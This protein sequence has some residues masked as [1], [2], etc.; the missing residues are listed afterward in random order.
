LDAGA[1]YSTYL[2]NT[3]SSNQVINVNTTGTYEVTVTDNNGCKGSGNVKISTTL[4]KPFDFLPSDTSLC[5]YGTM[6]LF[7]SISYNSYLWN[8][9]D[10]SHILTVTKPGLYW[11]QVKDK[12]NCTGRDSILL[13]LKDCMKGIFIP[14]A[15]SPNNDAI[16]NRFKPAI[17]GKIKY[18]KFS[19]YNRYGKLIFYSVNP[20]ESWDGTY[21]GAQQDC[22]VF[23]WICS[24]QFEGEIMKMEK[25]TVL[26]VR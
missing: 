11:L 1:G 4:P 13:R 17:F 25:G 24:Y 3:G 23:I 20:E 15:F 2:W 5:S 8:T 9:G 21:H 18:Y 16:N 10:N 7:S 12:N 26:L 19:I 6:R 22:N 14:S